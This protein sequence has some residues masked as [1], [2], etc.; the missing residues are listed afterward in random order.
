MTRKRWL[1][2]GFCFLAAACFLAVCSRSS[3]LYP[4]ND[5]VDVNI[6]ITMGRSMHAGK[7]LYTDVYDQKG[8]LL[9]YIYYLLT[10]FANC[11]LAE[12]V[13]EVVCYGLFLFF[14]AQCAA[15]YA[16]RAWTPYAVVLTLAAVV[17]ASN[18]FSLGGSVEELCLFM[19][20][21]PLYATLRAIRQKTF[22]TGRQALL[23]GAYA[24]VILWIKY[25]MLGFYAGLALFI[26]VWF[27]QARRYAALGRVIGCF[28]AGLA[29]VS[30]LTVS[31]FVYHGTLGDLW[32]AYF[33]NNIF[34]Y[35]DAAAES[36]GSRVFFV[37]KAGLENTLSFA[38]KNPVMTAL[39]LFGTAGCAVL[40]GGGAKKFV[41]SGE[42][43]ALVLPLVG[44]VFFTLFLGKSY[45]YYGLPLAVFAPFGAMLALK[46]A[47]RL[48]LR[49]AVAGVLSTALFAGALAA[50]VRLSQST[51]LLLKS[52]DEMTQ[53]QFAE[54]INQVEEATLLNYGFL[55]GGFYYA[56]DIVPENRFF[57]LLNIPLAEMR[58]EQKTWVEDGMTDFV[59]TQGA[60]LEWMGVDSSNYV[61][62]DETG[63]FAE[64]K[65]GEFTVNGYFLYQR[66]W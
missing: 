45:D 6:Y 3:F 52:R 10:T 62:V 20:M 57:C 11:Y 2:P 18:V 53:Y 55:D 58:E 30:A 43:C 24:G 26:A 66:T 27:L 32:T 4:M 9:Y 25:T 56:A 64:N 42:T 13:L 51:E 5:W 12:Y 36:A 7:L 21:H 40:R 65:D 60:M 48:R 34:I 39:V 23:F 44:V 46:P 15:L 1:L 41:H 35:S 29:I 8:P 22:L 19:M 14:A 50:D 28:L 49:P 61:C 31:Y 47:E 17:P 63:S 33:Y 16:R 38:R 59:V 54:I 37:L